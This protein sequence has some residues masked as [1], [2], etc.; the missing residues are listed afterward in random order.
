MTLYNVYITLIFT[1][2]MVTR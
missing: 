2:L 1:Y